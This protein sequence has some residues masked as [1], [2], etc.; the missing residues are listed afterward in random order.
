MDPKN[1]NEFAQKDKLDYWGMVDLYI[2]G[3]EHATGHL[4]YSRFW[5]KVLFDLGYVPA[6]IDQAKA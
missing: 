6:Y 2:G 3:S 5:Q 4:L 1:Q